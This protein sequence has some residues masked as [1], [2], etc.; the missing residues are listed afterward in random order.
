MDNERYQIIPHKRGLAVTGILNTILY[1]TAAFLILSNINFNLY[2]FIIFL[3]GSLFVV[4]FLD[5]FLW[6]QGFKNL[7]EETG[8]SLEETSVV[9]YFNAPNL[10]G[11][12]RGYKFYVSGFTIGYGRYKK[13][14]TKLEMDLPFDIEGSF[15]V[16]K[17]KFMQK[18]MELIGIDE[19][20]QKF[21]FTS[22]LAWVNKRLF[23]NREIVEGL[24][25]LHKQARAMELVAEPRKIIFQE[26]GR[27]R[28][29]KYLMAIMDYFIKL[30]SIFRNNIN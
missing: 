22:N 27:I 13:Q 10:S 14:F 26:Q 9:N 4:S 16:K 1:I 12:Y 3:F 8:L 28:D 11:S 17:L 19:F 5:I 24:F 7:G 15:S 23:Y 25:D 6:R 30:A 2:F 29:P 18:N 21:S 20:D